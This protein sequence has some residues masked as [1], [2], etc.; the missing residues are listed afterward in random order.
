MDV[1]GTNSVLT[2]FEEKVPRP[3]RKKCKWQ[4][5]FI[6][7]LSAKLNDNLLGTFEDITYTEEQTN[8]SVGL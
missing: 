3:V 6:V 4:S 2:S 7:E 5:T 1:I 8:S